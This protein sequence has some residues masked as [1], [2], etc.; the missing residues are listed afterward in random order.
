[1]DHNVPGTQVFIWRGHKKAPSGLSDRRAPSTSRP[2]GS[3]VE[4]EEKLHR[5][6]EVFERI[7]Y[8]AHEFHDV[9]QDAYLIGLEG[10]AVAIHDGDARRRERYRGEQC[11]ITSYL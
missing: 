5:I 3:N 11:A 10:I 4:V 8:I 1:M 2:R 7:E 9:F 6:E